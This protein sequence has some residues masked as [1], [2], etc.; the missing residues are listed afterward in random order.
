MTNYP[1]W[2][3]TATPASARLYSHPDAIA[4]EHH[5]GVRAM[6]REFGRAL[7]SRSLSEIGVELLNGHG[8][9]PASEL[10][11]GR[12][13]QLDHW[14]QAI[15]Y[16]WRCGVSVVENARVFLPF[17]LIV[18]GDTL[19]QDSTRQSRASDSGLFLR[20]AWTDHQWRMAHYAPAGETLAGDW[21]WAYT[22]CENY[23]HELADNVWRAW[24]MARF[25]DR[26][27]ATVFAGS[28]DRRTIPRAALYDAP[29]QLQNLPWGVYRVE[30][31][32]VPWCECACDPAT[33]P[34]PIGF[35][36]TI[37]WMDWLKNRLVKQLD[38][39]ELSKQ[40]APLLLVR[41]RSSRSRP[42]LNEDRLIDTLERQ[43]IPAF[44]ARADDLAT[45]ITTSASHHRFIGA[46][47][48]ALSNVI[49]S[50]RFRQG[51][52]ELWE[53]KVP[54]LPVDAFKVIAGICGARHVHVALETADETQP[55]SIAPT[56]IGW[57]ALRA[58]SRNIDRH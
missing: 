12:N 1:R 32:H 26:F 24:L 48:A 19:W 33:S 44:S 14:S 42:L 17:G 36:P 16:R 43:S 13:A 51:D 27:P 20:S 55:P 31:L 29:Y 30:R 25:P 37:E 40:S 8:T 4:P 18:S 52:G 6:A 5:Q 38:L 7:Q 54:S 34:L 46:H 21:S 3:L 41:G 35:P 23:Y 47:G 56:R 49:W 22:R 9:L 57:R 39:S 28:D 2:L 45:Q 50:D 58:L 53:L 15:N 10:I 11:G